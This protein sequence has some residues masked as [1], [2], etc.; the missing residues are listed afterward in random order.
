VGWIVFLAEALLAWCQGTASGGGLKRQIRVGL[1]TTL[2]PAFLMPVVNWADH[3]VPLW[4]DQLTIGVGLSTTLYLLWLATGRD[5]RRRA[6]H[7][8]VPY[9]SES[10]QLDTEGL[11]SDHRMHPGDADS[12][13]A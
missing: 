2:P 7:G 4:A 11:L 12:Q 3:A 6:E 10:P 8:R 9:Q 13:A 5:I 1:I